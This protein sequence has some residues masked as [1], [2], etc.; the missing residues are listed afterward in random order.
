MIIHVDRK[1]NTIESIELQQTDPAAAVCMRLTHARSLTA[2]MMMPIV[3]VH[4]NPC[5]KTI[6]LTC[7]V[8]FYIIVIV[9]SSH[10]DVTAH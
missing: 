3:A 1:L 4:L 5:M 10:S 8:V 2:F 9:G 6:K 7:N